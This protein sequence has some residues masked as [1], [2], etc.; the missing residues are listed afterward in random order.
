MLNYRL[1]RMLQ[2]ALLLL[3]AV[4][5]VNSAAELKVHAASYCAG[6]ACAGPYDCGTQCFCNYQ[7]GACVAVSAE[8]N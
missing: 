2:I 8:Q 3:L 1:S 6:L 4:L 7:V 5:A